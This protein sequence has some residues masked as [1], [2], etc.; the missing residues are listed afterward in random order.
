MSLQQV[1]VNAFTLLRQHPRVFIPRLVMTLVWSVFWVV[2]IG[3]LENPA[4]ATFRELGIVSLFFLMMLPFQI[5]VYN[6]YFLMVKQYREDDFALVAAFKQAIWKLPHGM[7]AF[8]LIVATAIA[9]SLPGITALIYGTVTRLP[10]MQ[11]LG[12]LM[13]IV[14]VVGVLIFSFF[15][16]ASVVLGEQS[17]AQNLK[18]GVLAAH[19]ERRE[20]VLITVVSFGLLFLTQLAHSRLAFLGI[21]GFVLGRLIAA[22]VSVYFLLVN[23]ELFLHATADNS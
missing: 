11:A 1:L 22:V 19:R 2:I 15:A 9:L 4:N 13:I 17:F 14:A 18:N 6:A 3:L 12:V 20:V 8:A 16:P 5:W 10:F 21:V 23:P 7:A